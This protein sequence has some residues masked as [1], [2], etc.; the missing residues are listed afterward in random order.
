[1]TQKL[2]GER[3]LGK[4]I[5]SSIR[6]FTPNLTNGGHR[7]SK[8]GGKIQRMMIKTRTWSLLASQKKASAP[9]ARR[10]RRHWSVIRAEFAPAP[11]RN[12]ADDGSCVR[13]RRRS[14]MDLFAAF[15][16][17]ESAP[18]FLVGE[19]NARKLTACLSI[20]FMLPS[21]FRLCTRFA[22]MNIF[23]FCDIHH[24]I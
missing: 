9:Y 18:N 20:A 16:N 7:L 4:C 19:L 17:S 3:K 22:A 23:F 11:S 24:T 5:Q 1:M 10:R 13:R 15:R 14:R 12:R 2:S 8:I 6:V 21:A